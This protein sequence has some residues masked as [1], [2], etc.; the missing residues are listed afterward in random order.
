MF[1][2][3]SLFAKQDELAMRNQPQRTRCLLVLA[4]FALCGQASAAE[5]AC[6]FEPE[7]WRSYFLEIHRPNFPDTA[8]TLHKS[9]EG[10]FRL[11]IDRATGA[12]TEV[13]VLKSTGVKILDD[14]AAAT[15]LQWKAK[16]HLIDHAVLPVEFGP[17]GSTESH[18]K[19]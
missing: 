5:P 7:D 6:K 14:S 1:T 17:R 19:W 8:A 12:V 13:K 9:G 10:C 3:A 11:T 16:P 2:E 18:I 4:A 15:F